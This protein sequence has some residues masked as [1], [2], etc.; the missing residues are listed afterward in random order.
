MV[1]QQDF[2][3]LRHFVPDKN[4]AGNERF[5]TADSCDEFSLPI[6]NKKALA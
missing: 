5:I 4:H 2:S 1:G 3:A 6:E